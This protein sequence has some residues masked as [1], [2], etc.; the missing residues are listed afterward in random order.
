MQHK[1]GVIHIYKIVESSWKLDKSFHTNFCHY[2]RLR[3]L[4][5]TEVLIPLSDSNVGVYSLQTHKIEYK[6]NPSSFPSSEKLGEPM[7]IAP[8]NKDSDHVLIAYEGGKMLLWD[9]KKRQVLS[10]LEIENCPMAL[11][12]DMFFKR[13]IIGGPS[14][15]LQVFD[16]SN[17]H[18]LTIRNNVSVRNPGT[19]IINIRA[20][21]KITA[22]GGWDGRVR[23][24]SWKNMRPLAVLDQHRDTVHDIAFS[25]IKVQSYDSKVLMA[26]GAKD[27]YVALWDIY[28]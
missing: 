27:G 18:S 4:S 2:C 19:S 1:S 20:D 14:E 21:S 25:P 8:L 12:F 9:L 3:I 5:D 13:G 6:L 24:Y 22:V 28:N 11:D 10:N 23:V 7:V 16:L 26:T 15:W 17:S